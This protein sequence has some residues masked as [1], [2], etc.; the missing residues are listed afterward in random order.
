M[1]PGESFYHLAN[2]PWEKRNTEFFFQR[3]FEKEEDVYQKL[4]PNNEKYVFIHD[5]ISRGFSINIKTEHKIIKNNNNINMLHLITLLERAEEIHC[6]S[7]SILCLIDCLSSHIQFKNL[8]LH[9]NIRKVE[10]GPN[11]LFAN[12]NII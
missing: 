3:E 6:M 12:W 4:N 8:Y 1:G 9:Y 10:L 5:D 11:S 2:V 7:S